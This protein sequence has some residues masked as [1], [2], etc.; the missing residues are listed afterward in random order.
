MVFGS[1]LK[2]FARITSTG[3]FIPEIDGMRFIAIALVVLFHL[4]SHSLWVRPAES[5]VVNANDDWIARLTSH[6]YYGV[7]F[8][9][10]ISGF[11][12]ALPFAARWL[13]G[14]RSVPLRQYY[15]RRL[16][17]LEPPYIVCMVGLF[18][19]LAVFASS[20]SVGAQDMSTVARGDRAVALLPSLLASLV[21]QHNL[22]FGHESYINFVAWSLEIEV[23]FYLLVPLLVV[24]F[25]VRTKIARRIVIAIAVLAMA[26]VQAW[27]EPRI[28]LIHLTIL[29]HLQYFLLGFI[30]A[31]IYLTDWSKHPATNFMWDLATLAAW[32]CLFVVW[33]N[34]LFVL[35]I[36]PLLLMIIYIA[37][38][39]GRISNL[40]FRHPLIVTIGGMCY[41]IY[42]L[43]PFLMSRIARFT[44]RFNPTDYFAIQFV[45]RCVTVLPLLLLLSGIF[46]VLI[47]KPCMVRDWPQRLWRKTRS[48]YVR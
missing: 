9:F 40:I 23:Q 37:A 14:G 1:L 35:W 5:Y 12:L 30:L 4:R 47:E 34:Q 27:L 15:L 46:F 41:S 6:G 7:Q 28:P 2:P 16:T 22:V 33:E 26:A 10:V 19:W 48:L 38:F 18:L 42:L 31:D 36:M 17:R 25:R 3:R 13:E 24:V 21:Y 43:H 29:G 32:F 44:D 20:W 8:F 11:I 39:R 45:V